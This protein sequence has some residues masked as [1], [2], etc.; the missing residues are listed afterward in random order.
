MLL[1]QNTPPSS[2]AEPG[3]AQAQPATPAGQPASAPEATQPPTANQP[4]GNHASAPIKIAP[5]SVIPVQLAKTVEAK[6]AKT[7]DEVVATVTMDMKNSS[8]DIL[9]PKD[10]RIVGHVTEAQ[11]RNKDQKESQLGIAFDHAVVK[12]D[13]MQLPMS[14]QAIIAPQTNNPAQEGGNDTGASAGAQPATSSGSA[15]GSGRAGSM[16]G[17]NPAPQQQQQNYPQGGAASASQPQT[18]AHP[19]ITGNTQGVIGMPDLKLDNST[20]AA[21][22]GSVVSSEKNNVKIE[23]GTM[24]LLRVNQ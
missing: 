1:A 12:G 23:K 6:K 21:N 14:I 10:T 3:A 9:V 20:Q 7:G 8:G 11:A 17:S 13:Q 16:G 22:Q 5:G 18:S 4:T 15:M 2:T 24:L 19:P